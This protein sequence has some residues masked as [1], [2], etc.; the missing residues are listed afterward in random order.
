MTQKSQH[1]ILA[2]TKIIAIQKSSIQ[3]RHFFLQGR[4]E[5]SVRVDEILIADQQFT[6]ATDL[7]LENAG[8]KYTENGI[9]VNSCTCK[10]PL[11]IFSCR[12]KCN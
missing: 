2:R 10:L 6:P 9:L 8:V 4:I 1:F 5:K 7:G 3:K 11:G 12:R